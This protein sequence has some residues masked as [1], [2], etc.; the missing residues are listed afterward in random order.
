MMR[1]SSGPAAAALRYNYQLE[2]RQRQH[3]PQRDMN[4]TSANLDALTS[5]IALCFAD[6]M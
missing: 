6:T 4:D 1:T 2:L 5:S 3:D